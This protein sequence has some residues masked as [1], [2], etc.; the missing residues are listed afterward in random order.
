MYTQKYYNKITQENNESFLNQFNIAWKGFLDN[1][2]LRY[3]SSPQLYTGNRLR[4]IIAC[5]GYLH[6]HDIKEDIDFRYIAEITVSLEALHKASVI[7]DDVIDGDTMRRG[8]NCV[9]V[10]YSE[11]E[12]V[13]FAVCLISAAIDNLNQKL[14]TNFEQAWGIDAVSLLCNTI[15]KM[16]EGAL[17]EITSTETDRLNMNRIQEIIN[18]ETATL[19]KNSLLI[20]YIASNQNY[21][22]NMSDTI[23]RIGERCGFIFQV[24]NDLE[25]F[26]NPD[27]IKKHKGNLNSDYLKSRKNIVIPYMYQA[28]ST[29]KRKQLEKIIENNENFN[30]I[31]E[32]FEE[33]NLRE[34]IMKDIE[35]LHKIIDEEIDSM[36]LWCDNTIWINSFKEFVKFLIDYCV[37]VLDG[38]PLNWRG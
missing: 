17:L 16:C 22:P 4:P 11:N 8:N 32:L 13:F 28:L 31:Q 12:T 9:H 26:C 5:W 37:S 38:T 25:P 36:L 7:I 18:L 3:T 21:N 6:C 29:K 1:M 24:L 14:G 19:L 15:F 10:D 30:V 27:Y 2:N 20:G 33:F 35:G 23:E 34:Y